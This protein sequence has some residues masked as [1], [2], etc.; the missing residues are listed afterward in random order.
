MPLPR[1]V[2]V[3]NKRF[4]NRFIEPIVSRSDDFA[5]IHHVGRRSGR[6]FTTPVKMFFVDGDGIVALT[7]G[8]GAD[9]VQNV[10]A[11]GG[12]VEHHGA[13]HQIATVRVVG[14]TIAW[15]ALSTL[16]RGALRVLTVEDFLRIR[17]EPASES[18]T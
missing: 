1:A 13:V 11:S 6:K 2:A 7:Y 5:R 18:A 17:F 10:I 9:W 8:P 15:P 14:R 4:T 12:A 16:V 3:L